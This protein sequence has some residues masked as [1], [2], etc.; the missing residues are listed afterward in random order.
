MGDALYNEIVYQFTGVNET[1]R[2]EEENDAIKSN[3]VGETSRNAVVLLEEWPDA[4]QKDKT[5]K[6]NGN[7]NKDQG[8]DIL[9]RNGQTLV[10][11]Q[12]GEIGAKA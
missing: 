1:K 3:H 9:T 8:S 10:R 5:I 7:I 6:D 4:K 2:L 12:S 11:F